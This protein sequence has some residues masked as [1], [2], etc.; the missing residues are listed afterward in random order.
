[1]IFSLISLFILAGNQ[2]ADIAFQR[3]N[4]IWDAAYSRMAAQTD[5]WFKN[6]DF[7]RSIQQLKF[8]YELDPHDYHIASDLAWMLENIE[9]YEEAEAVYAR[10]IRDNPGDPD[11]ALP[12]AQS[13]F[14][15]KE[16]AKVIALLEPVLSDQAHPNVFRLLAHAYNRTEK[17]KDALRVWDWYLRLHPGDEAGKRN[18][19]N[20]AKKIGG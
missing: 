1:M 7:P 11:R 13:A 15:N 3:T 17:F 14:N 10:Y 4:L 9:E 20:V 16:Y 12:P 19:D 5:Y 6:G 2:P 8:T 18:R